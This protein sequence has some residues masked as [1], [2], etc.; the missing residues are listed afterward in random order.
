MSNQTTSFSRIYD[1]FLVNVTDDMYLE[2]SEPET[3]MML[4]DLL[5]SAIPQFEFP[6]FNI[7]DYELTYI[8]DEGEYC[9]VDSSYQS[10]H[11]YYCGGG[12][13][14]ASLS[15][16]EMKILVYYMI[17]DWIGQQLASVE[18]TRQKYTGSDFKMTSQASHLQKLLTMKKDYERQGFHLQRLYKR[19]KRSD[20]GLFVPT[21]TEIVEYDYSDEYEE[22]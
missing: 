4:Q 10:V 14:N 2:L 7:E 3:Y 9:G 6:R 20:D 19:R 12:Y 5:I 17:A 18:M 22:E 1:M 15:L 21:I 16:E 11:C 8:E 13:F